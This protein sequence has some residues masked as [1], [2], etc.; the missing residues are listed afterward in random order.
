[1]KTKFLFLIPF[2]LLTSCL[3]S[4][5][6][7]LSSSIYSSSE[8]GRYEKD[9]EGFYILEKDYFS[10]KEDES[11]LKKRNQVFIEPFVQEKEQ[12]NQLR[13]YIGDKRVPIYEVKTNFS[14]RWNPTAHNRMNNGVATIGLEG[15]VEIK[16]QANF[17]FMN[18]ISIR[19]TSRDVKY[20]VDNSRR[21]I[22]FTIS[23][24]GQYT[25][26]LRSGRTLHL[27]VNKMDVYEVPKGAIVF[28]P[29][30]HNKSNDNRINNNN[31]IV[32]SSG[33]VYYLSPGC[34]LDA[35]FYAR[36]RNNITICGPGYI[37]GSMF[38]RDANK[39]TTLVP[40][41]INFVNNLTLKD[42]SVIDPAGWCF[43]IYFDTQVHIENTKIISSRSNGDGISLQSCQHVLVENVFVRSWDDSLVIKNY[44]NYTSGVEGVTRD[45]CC[46]N[47]IIWTD[48]A[49][50][51]EVG[52]ETIGEIM[53]DICF[54]NI[55]VL[56]NYHR[57]IF[58][59]HN[60]NNANIKRVSFSNIT[61][62]DASM[63][64][65]D[66]E[67]VIIDFANIFSS[68][69]SEAHKVTSLGTIDDVNVNNVIVIGGKPNPK[70]RIKG[71]IDTRPQYSKEP[72]I[73]S[74]VVISDFLLYD[75]VLTK[76]YS[77]L[78]TKY[79]ENV[80]FVTSGNKITGASYSKPDVSEYGNN[81]TFLP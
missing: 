13:M 76:D 6:S 7:F 4:G 27:F 62:E 63:G 46:K 2:I 14:Q 77:N 41:D 30:V 52:Y 1:M 69:W 39:G 67:N 61:V 12:Y 3:G 49:Q 25:I 56:H 26:E 5:S 65:G 35:R 74:N 11:D 10:Y 57:A 37:D 51:M 17:A 8:E 21:V 33:N 80:T 73:V 22:T 15:K 40:I 78:E 23:D 54:E 32:L 34:F 29:G 53:E 20:V 64:G 59:I 60:G 36:S 75:D 50:S 9:D 42:F 44:V 71:A 79:V 31:E 55:T 24:V 68:N 81:I 16:L 38:E 58:S 43:N 66:G 28:E 48:L 72:H 18:E 45:I 47:C 70:V 19:P